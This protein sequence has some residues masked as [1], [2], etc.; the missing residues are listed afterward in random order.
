MAALVRKVHAAMNE[1]RAP[2][3]KRQRPH[4]PEHG[5]SATPPHVSTLESSSL[6]A[7][8]RCRQ[9]ALRARRGAARIGNQ[10]LPT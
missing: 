8:E 7:P 10:S 6:A 2:L 3:A 5:A 1:A 9:D 4:S